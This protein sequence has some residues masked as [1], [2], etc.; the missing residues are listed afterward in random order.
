MLKSLYNAIRDDAVAS[1]A[2]EVD[3]RTYTSRPLAPVPTPT[4][5]PLVVH[6]LS[7]LR[8]YIE[9]G[10]DECGDY[11]LLV[12]TPCKVSLK[13]KIIGSFR[14][15]ETLCIAE[16]NPPAFHFN[17][18]LSPEEF[19]IGLQSCF[20]PEHD[21][22]NVLQYVS[23]VK[24]VLGESVS[25]DG[26]S[27]TVTV[28]KGISQMGTA[29]L[30]N[31]VTLTPIRYFPDV[32]QVLSKYVFRAKKMDN[33]IGFRLIEADGGGWEMAAIRVLGEYLKELTGNKLPVIA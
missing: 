2:V 9:S 24:A 30:P 16:Y 21:Y 5:T 4:A 23:D 14:E 33:G 6:T 15:R 12:E 1:I 11:F 28:K 10:I 27:Q 20:L 22:V 19:I 25:D 7:G 18:W 8:G 32:E 17:T 29:A 31:P 13:S 26:I 3:G